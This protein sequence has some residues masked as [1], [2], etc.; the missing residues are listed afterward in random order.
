MTELGYE[1]VAN[2]VCRDKKDEISKMLDY[3]YSIASVVLCTGG[4]GPTDDDITRGAISEYFGRKLLFDDKIWT[5]ISD[6]YVNYT[7]QTPPEN[8]KAQALIPEGFNV[9]S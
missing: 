9:F 8:N 5:Q 2:L 4:L 3:S 7:G 1:V 6:V